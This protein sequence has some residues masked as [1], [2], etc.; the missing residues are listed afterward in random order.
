MVY[1][2]KS[3]VKD[4]FVNAKRDLFGFAREMRKEPSES[5]KILWEHLRKMRSEGFIFRRQHPNDIFITDFYPLA[6][7]ERGNEGVRS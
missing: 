2:G 6:L 3:K 7:R 1:L 5:E 4:M